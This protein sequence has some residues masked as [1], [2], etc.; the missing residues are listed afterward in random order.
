MTLKIIKA[1]E[2]VMKKLPLIYQKA[3]L[4]QAAR[5]YFEEL[6]ILEIR[7]LV[8][9]M[10]NAGIYLDDFLDIITI[11]PIASS[12]EIRP[13]FQRILAYFKL[14]VTSEQEAA[15][16]L[17]ANYVREIIN[18]PD[19]A[20]NTMQ[21]LVSFLGYAIDKSYD[22]DNFCR[23]SSDLDDIYD[24]YATPERIACY[25]NGESY[26]KAMGRIQKKS[27]EEAQNW[28]KNHQKDI[29]LDFLTCINNE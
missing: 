27:V 2:C 12:Q 11:D 26:E 23:L 14:E 9:Q 29:P 16:I 7:P 25:S 28:L 5:L 19:D 8:D 20:I 17:A 22:I 13:P 4:L 6:S 3:L 18:Y 1:Q 10:L 21:S 24:I 15:W